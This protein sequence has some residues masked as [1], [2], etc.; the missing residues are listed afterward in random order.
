[1]E[2]GIGQV[3]NLLSV[4]VLKDDDVHDTSQLLLLPR[5]AGYKSSNLLLPAT[6]TRYCYHAQCAMLQPPATATAHSALQFEL[7]PTVSTSHLVQHGLQVE[8]LWR[9]HRPQQ[10]VDGRVDV[11]AVLGVEGEV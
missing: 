8:L 5:T 9:G 1:M 3:I 6:A 4:I 11:R 7:S 10:V 2:A